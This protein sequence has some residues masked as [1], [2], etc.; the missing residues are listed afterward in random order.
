MQGGVRL[1]GSCGPTA[2][3]SCVRPINQPPSQLPTTCFT[4]HADRL[5]G[6]PHI[7][8]TAVAYLTNSFVV[9]LLAAYFAGS[10]NSW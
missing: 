7:P 1:L 9:P 8:N 2:L 3:A 10:S 4:L 5:T 6:P